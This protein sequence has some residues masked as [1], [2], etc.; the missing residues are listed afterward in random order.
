MSRP[1]NPAKPKVAL[2]PSR[3]RREPV[4]LTND[5]RAE[6]KAV[7]VSLERQ[8]WG[9]VSGVILFAIALAVLVVAISIATFTRYDPAAAAAAARFGQCYNAFGPN[10]V[11]DG[12]TA[13][14]G[15]EKVRIAGI[16]APRIQGARCAEEKER[17]IDAALRL[18]ELLNGG[19]VSLGANITGND[20]QLRRKIEVDGQDIAPAMVGDGLARPD[21]AGEQD[22]CD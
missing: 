2:K 1:W 16:D 7:A 8:L 11:I 6:R 15:G 19:K 18:A 14:V 17:G 21:D 10:C 22:W 9:G 3:I 13:Y 20:G 4:R 12:G 5:A